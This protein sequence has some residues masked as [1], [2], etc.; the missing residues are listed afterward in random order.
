MRLMSPP[1]AIPATRVPKISGAM[2]DRISR[3]K[4]ALDGGQLLRGAGRRH[5]ARQSRRHPDEDPRGQG[6]PPHRSPHFSFSRSTSKKSC[7]AAGS[8]AAQYAELR[9][10]TQSPSCS[11]SPICPSMVR[12]IDSSSPRQSTRT[13]LVA[14]HDHG[15]VGEHVG[16]DGRQ[17]D[18]RHGGE[19]DGAACRERVSRGA[20]GGAD[21]QA[22]GLVGADELLVHVGFEVDHAGQRGLSSPPRR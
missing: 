18:G 10:T 16:A 3:R 9:H 1:P 20:G 11:G 17:A 8:G 19:D 15:P 7:A 4:I 12:K 13:T 21:D 5:P 14:G 2:M 22:V 6:N